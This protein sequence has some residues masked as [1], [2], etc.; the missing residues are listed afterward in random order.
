MRRLQEVSERL[1]EINLL[2]DLATNT[3]QEGGNRILAN[4]ITRSALVLLTGYFEGGIRDIAEEFVD[5][6]N[7]NEVCISKIPQAMLNLLAEEAVDAFKQKKTTTLEQL[8]QNI[9]TDGFIEFNKKKHVKTNA[10]P[11]VDNIELLFSIFGLNNI[12][13]TLS[14]RDFGLDST[15]TS[16]S[17]I[18]EQLK[19]RISSTL[20]SR[21]LDTSELLTDIS[22]AIETKWGPKKKRRKVGYVSQIEELLKKRNRIAHGEGFEPITPEELKSYQVAI[23]QLLSGI[24]E[25]LDNAL[26]DLITPDNNGDR[27]T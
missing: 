15:Y 26:A 1:N 19:E 16:E 7:D 20:T 4:A 13:D 24:T 8:S 6:I 23:N 18:T 11:T 22:E 21:G 2:A 9:R 17:Q 12:I 25:L 10:N 3:L 5:S 14:I 27:V